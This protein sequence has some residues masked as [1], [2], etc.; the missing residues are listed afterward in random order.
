[1]VCEQLKNKA[2]QSF[3]DTF[4]HDA[5]ALI[6]APGRVNLIGEHTDY[7]DGFVLPMAIDYGTVIAIGARE[8]R[9]VHT[10][11]VNFDNALDS[12]DLSEKIATNDHAHWADHIRGIAHILQKREFQ[13]RG[14]NMAIV[15]NV[16][17]GAGLS[18]SASLGVATAMAMAENS[19]MNGLSATDF[20]VIAQ[21]SENEF[22]GTACGIM[23]QLVSARAEEGSA[24]LIDC[25]SLDC[26]PVKMPDDI[27]ILIIH[28][29]VRRE[30]ADS[31]YNE[32]RAQCEAVAKYFGVTALR[33]VN[34]DQLA[35]DSR[36]IDSTAFR[37]ARHV[38]SE[39]HRTQEAAKALASGDLTTMGSLMAESHISMRDDFEITTAKVDELVKVA[40]EA[41]GSDG[42]ARMTGG[43]FGGCVVAIMPAERLE[44]VVAQI[45]ERYET[46]DGEKPQQI[47]AQ[48]SAGA[49]Q[50][51]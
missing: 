41:V 25:R 7:N 1:M 29:G 2:R 23:D 17:S 49:R 13:L 37:R 22:V 21:Q 50:L 5:E 38:I 32:R 11:A 24:L 20:A 46:P 36:A 51:S 43:G 10:L 48:P 26:R 44:C 9:Q 35:A 12:F 6:Q 19:Y 34:M 28:S 27:A 14:S 4:G 8:D 3:K 42:G 45:A 15:G 33:D 31:K 16:P 18:S 47:I 40:Q 30:L 39:N